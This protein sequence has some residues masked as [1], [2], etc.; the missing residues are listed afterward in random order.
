MFQSF[1]G[2]RAAVNETTYKLN[3]STQLSADDWKKMKQVV[4][5]LKP[6]EEGT[7][8]LSCHDASISMAISTVTT[9]MV[10]LEDETDED[11]GVKG[12]M[13]KL[14][15]NMEKRF[16]NMENVEHYTLATLLD[17]HFKGCFFR[18]PNTL[19]DTKQKI[20]E[21][22]VHILNGEASTAQV[23]SIN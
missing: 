4:K 9:I 11:I 10:S 13:R 22:I 17:G 1:L 20:I 3:L 6:F 19:E 23:S 8:L 7:K 16:G 2:Q 18:K 21:K 12:M 5:I 15:Q 14:K